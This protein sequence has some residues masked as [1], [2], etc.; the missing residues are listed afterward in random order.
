M[1]HHPSGSYI[2]PI[3]VRTVRKD[4]HFWGKN[5]YVTITINRRGTFEFEQLN[6]SDADKIIENISNSIDHN[7]NF[8]NNYDQAYDEGKSHGYEDGHRDGSRDGFNEGYEHAKSEFWIH[9]REEVRLNDYRIGYQTG[10][11]E[12]EDEARIQWDLGYNAGAKDVEENFE[13][14]IKRLNAQKNTAEKS[15]D[16]LRVENADLRDKL[17][18]RGKSTNSGRDA[19]YQSLKRVI[20]ILLHPD[21]SKGTSF[22]KISDRSFLKK[23]GQKSKK[24]KNLCE[25][26]CILRKF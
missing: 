3:F 20:A 8:S 11:R 5:Y 21:N 26:V 12:A 18:G 10:R 14:T 15:R 7:K 13:Q 25:I 6:E 1:L 24:S 19:K 4:K 2:N 9:D 17:F 23:Y 16:E 22:E